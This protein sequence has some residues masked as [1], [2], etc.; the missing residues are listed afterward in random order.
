MH[1]P[2]IA[3]EFNP[4]IYTFSELSASIPFDANYYRMPTRLCEDLE[5]VTREFSG[6]ADILIV[7]R[8]KAAL[9][10]AA[11]SCHATTFMAQD[12]HR[13]SK[14][15]APVTVAPRRWTRNEAF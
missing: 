10:Q 6:R 14:Y 7:P 2:V 11:G 13:T 5:V 15:S 9:A 4:H 12:P 3:L 1:E 8:S